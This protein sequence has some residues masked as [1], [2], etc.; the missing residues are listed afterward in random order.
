[1]EPFAHT[2]EPKRELRLA[3]HVSFHRDTDGGR[4]YRTFRQYLTGREVAHADIEANTEVGASEHDQRDV[5]RVRRADH[6]RVVMGSAEMCRSATTGW[7]AAE[8][9]H[10]E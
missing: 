6:S 5:R 3:R 7:A 1:V 10:D 2:C 9:T 4:Q 8:T